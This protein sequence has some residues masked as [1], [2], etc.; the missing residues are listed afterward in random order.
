[1]EEDIIIE[2]YVKPTTSEVPYSAVYKKPNTSYGQSVL[3]TKPECWVW[4]L[5]YYILEFKDNV[6]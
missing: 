3:Y 6:N 5:Y 2:I 1:V 4:A